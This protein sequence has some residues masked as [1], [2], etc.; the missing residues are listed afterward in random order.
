[1]SDPRLTP[2]RPD[3]AA[4][5]LRGQVSAE[6]YVE[7]RRV[8]IAVALAALRRRPDPAA[9]L[10]TQALYGETLAVYEERDG[11]AWGQLERDGYVGYLKASALGEPQP[12]THRVAAL[13]THAY[14][15]PNIKLPPA[16]A[17]PLGARIAM[18]AESGDFLLDGQ[19]RCYWKR[20]LAPAESAEPDFVAVAETFLHAPY[21]WGGRTSEGIDC[22]GLTQ[23]GL[24]AAGIA[25][26]RDSDMLE[27]LGTSVDGPLKRGDLVF[28]RGH[29]GIM[30]DAQRLL[31]ANGWHMSVVSEPLTEARARI[32]AGGGG[33]IT[34]IRRL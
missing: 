15:G 21:L 3:L 6:R 4:A 8:Q 32:A 7:G 23:A 5:S 31:H 29:V 26:P 17:L 19:G 24:T 14:P 28:W 9:S 27:K 25:A 30:Q 34:S 16:M 18:A 12:A 22:S 11:W 2:A 1:M 33:E 13:R 20:H 10:E